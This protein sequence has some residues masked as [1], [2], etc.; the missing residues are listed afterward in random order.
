MNFDSNDPHPR[1][2]HNNLSK[3][4]KKTF[5]ILYAFFQYLDIVDFNDL[6][7]HF[8]TESKSPSKKIIELIYHSFFPEGQEYQVFIRSCLLL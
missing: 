3:F 1:S 7:L 6:L 8:A 4:K 2:F 5:L